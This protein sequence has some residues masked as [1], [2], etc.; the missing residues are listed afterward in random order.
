[1]Q[2]CP[3][4]MRLETAV[5]EVLLSLANLATM[6]AEM[7]HTGNDSEFER[8]DKQIELIVGEKERAIGALRQH[9]K[10]HRCGPMR[11]AA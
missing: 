5:R 4:Y 7:S 6:Q 8:L 1:M 9:S 3:E 11:I 10:E 2:K